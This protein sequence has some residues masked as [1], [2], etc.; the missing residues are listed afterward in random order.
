M[1]NVELQK[2][3]GEIQKITFLCTARKHFRLK[4]REKWG[5]ETLKI[6]KCGTNMQLFEN[7]CGSAENV[8]TNA[9]L[10][11]VS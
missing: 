5:G 7:E 3:T 11:N 9:S 2:L 6:L 4:K 8:F 1:V 10:W